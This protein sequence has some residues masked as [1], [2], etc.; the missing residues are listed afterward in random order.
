M[1]KTFRS[2]RNR[3]YRIWAAGALVS[4]VGTWMQRIAQDWLVLTE[5]TDHNATAVGI[6]M[7]LQYGPHILLLPWTGSMA[8]R[9]DRRRLLIT[10]QVIQALLALVLGVLT[11]SGHVALWHVYGFAFLLGCTSAFDA[12]ARHTFVVD[13]VGEADLSNAVAL[14][15]TSFN[16]ARMMGPA[17][18]GLLIAAVG[19]G[20][21]FMLNALSF[22]A[23]IGALHALR[24]SEL[25]V[26]VRAARAASQ[27]MD[28]LRYVQG[29]PD[30]R[31]QLLMVFL[32]GTFGLNFALF[33]STMSV[34]IFHGDAAQYGLLM[35]VMAI[36]S[37]SGALLAAGRERP[38]MML[39]LTSA[40]AFGLSCALAACMPG[41]GWFAASLVLIGISAMTFTNSSASLAQLASAPHMRGRVTAIRLA[42]MMG[43]TPIGA[44]LVGWTADHWGPRW[45]MGIGAAAGILAALV[46]VLYLVRHRQLRVVR[47]AGRWRLRMDEDPV[48][49]DP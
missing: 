13:L 27:F 29:R 23:L 20:W 38:N 35:S 8:D 9:V 5:L 21:A 39:L 1:R 11:V 12:P 41:P 43:G 6:V 14:N 16:A 47:G 37:I 28:G 19:T 18:A 4:N 31:A 44:P 33:I 2:L 3:N 45:A 46:G 34:T 32:I 25:H 7:A 26:S 24:Q 42:I 30:L 48:T 36:G 40:A 10:T 15:S 22:V 17:V 49:L